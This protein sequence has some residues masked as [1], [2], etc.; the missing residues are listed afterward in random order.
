[1]SSTARPRRPRAALACGHASAAVELAHQRVERLGHDDLPRER[2]VTASRAASLPVK[3]VGVPA[4]ALL[5]AYSF[6][7]PFLPRRCWRRRR[8]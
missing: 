1:M 6:V 7:S 3:L 8:S 4:G 5:F 2:I